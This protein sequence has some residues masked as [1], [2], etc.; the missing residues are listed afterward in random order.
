M[1][2]MGSSKQTMR[3]FWILVAVALVVCFYFTGHIGAIMNA[4]P[5]MVMVDALLQAPD[6]LMTQFFSI[7]FNKDAFMVM[8]VLF[9]V[10]VGLVY[11]ALISRKKTRIGEE[12]GSAKWLEDLKEYNKTY[13]DPKGSPKKDGP[14][15]AIICK[16]IFLST[17]GY[18][19][20]RNNNSLVIGGSGTGKSRFY[21]KP[22]LLQANTSYV[23]TD[24]SGELLE[25]TGGF[26]KSQGYEVKVFNLSAM[27]HSFTYNPFNYVRDEVTLL[28]MITCIIDNTTPKGASKGDPFW[29]KSESLLLQALSGYLLEMCRPAER[30]LAN[31]M[32]LTRQ[33]DIREDAPADYKDT[34]DIMF[35][36]LEQRNPNSFALTQYKAY[37]LAAG[38]TAKSIIVSVAARLSHFNIQQVINLTSSDTIDLTSIGDKKTVLY[39]ITPTGDRTF[40]YII[41][42]MYS[43]LFLSLY[44]HAE[45]DCDGKRLPVHVR[46]LLDEFA[47]IGTIPDFCEKLSTMRKYEI[48]CAI[49]I[50]S[51]SQLKTMYKDDW[52]VLVD[53][54]DSKLFLGAQGN[55][56]LKF[57]SELLGKETLYAQNTSETYGMQQ[58]ATTSWNSVGRELMTTNELA[59]MKNDRCVVMIRGVYPY[60]GHKYDY[61]KHPNYKYTG[62]KDKKLRFNIKDIVTPTTER[63]N[64]SQP[65]KKSPASAIVEKPDDREAKRLE[66]LKKR[67]EV[68]Q[69]SEKGKL[70]HIHQEM[71]EETVKRTFGTS[72]VKELSKEVKIDI[73]GIVEAPPEA[74][75]YDEAPQGY[76]GNIEDINIEDMKIEI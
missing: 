37:K 54:C 75:A 12:N 1:I 26:F 61:P 34:L 27:E 7:G 65:K 64:L 30:T 44:H 51:I 66:L 19:T 11:G 67:R 62:D 53:N 5:D 40:N 73:G 22:N 14:A 29:E 39:C 49:I 18:E 52:E 45:Y 2:S 48:S 76:E 63:L 59:V 4:N 36:R 46:F 74:F 68:R 33:A 35:D 6:H 50:Q 16:E 38:K 42:L 20:M 28:N 15:N 57:V 69:Q 60:F 23:V 71:N 9:I 13:T 31:V 47:N 17:K 8:G 10:V 56:T 25:S 58:S 43:Q 3:M 21:V 24:P 72:D 32:E 41:A 55:E 70:A